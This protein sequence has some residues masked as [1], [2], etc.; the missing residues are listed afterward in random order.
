M[1]L[2]VFNFSN[3]NEIKIILPY[4]F[5]ILDNLRREMQVIFPLHFTISAL[6]ID[7]K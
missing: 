3:Y 4:L 5:I 7:N 6:Y 1:S 2:F